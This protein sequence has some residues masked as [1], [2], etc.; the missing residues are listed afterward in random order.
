MPEH[1]TARERFAVYQ[2]HK[3]GLSARDIADSFGWN[4]PRRVYYML[5]QPV[6]PKKR[7]GRPK[8]LDT[9][10]RAKLVDILDNK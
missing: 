9:P 2:M 8:A 5:R 6:T 4:H 3:A 7:K 10:T 1:A